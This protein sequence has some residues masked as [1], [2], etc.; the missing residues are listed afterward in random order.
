MTRITIEVLRAHKACQPGIDDF[1][2]V[3]PS[4]IDPSDKAAVVSALRA[5]MGRW[6]RWAVEASLLSRDLSCANLTRATLTGATLYRA[7]LSCA[8]LTDADL[9]RADLYGANLTGA[10]LSGT[11]LRRADLT[12][13]YLTGA[14]YSANTILPAGLDPAARGMILEAK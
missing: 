7:D 2:R 14:R 10:D 11:N 3:C 8:N 6:W 4:G 12:D 9:R 5:G 1:A 13:A